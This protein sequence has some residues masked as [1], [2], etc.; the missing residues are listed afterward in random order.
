MET[1]KFLCEFFFDDYWHFLGGF[2]YLVVICG[3]RLISININKP[4]EN[5]K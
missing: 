4:A 1:I 5:N 3:F 2:V